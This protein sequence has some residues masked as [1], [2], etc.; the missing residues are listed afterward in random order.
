[1]SEY[2]MRD[3]EKVRSFDSC[4]RARR[5]AE[6]EV[7]RLRGLL[8]DAG[9][10]LHRHVTHGLTRNEASAMAAKCFAV[11]RRNGGDDDV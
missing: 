9:A 2:R 7:E 11:T 5:A 4:N 8:E 3:Y 1:M 6:A 10:T